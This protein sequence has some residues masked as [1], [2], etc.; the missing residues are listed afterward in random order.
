MT[1]MNAVEIADDDDF[2]FCRFREVFV[3]GVYVDHVIVA[4]KFEN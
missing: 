4:C 2:V 1:F 3:G